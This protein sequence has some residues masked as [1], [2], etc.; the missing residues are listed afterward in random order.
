[1]RSLLCSSQQWDADR[2]GSDSHHL[3]RAVYDHLHRLDPKVSFPVTDA[4]VDELAALGQRTLQR[5]GFDVPSVHADPGSDLALRQYA[6]ALGLVPMSRLE[7][8]RA[9]CDERLIEA[10]ERCLEDKPTRVVLCTPEPS[11]R[12]LAGIQRLRPRLAQHRVKLTLLKI[13]ETAGLPLGPGSTHRII[14]DSIRW[15]HDARTLRN[16]KLLKKLHVGLEAGVANPRAVVV[17]NPGT[18]E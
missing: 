12:L 16:R 15:R 5:F 3:V 1:M 10:L 7:T 14:A 8:E 2:C 4:Q 11:Q 13:D 18:S 9:A 6:A 17:R